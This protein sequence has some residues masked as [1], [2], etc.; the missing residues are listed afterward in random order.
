MKKLL[1]FLFLQSTLIGFATVQI[2]PGLTLSHGTRSYVINYVNE[3]VQTND[4]V[5]LGTDAEYSFSYVQLQHDYYDEVG[6][7][8]APMYPAYTMFLQVPLF[9]S[10]V[11]IHIHSLHYEQVTLNFPYIP[12]QSTIEDEEF[13]V[14]MDNSLYDDPASMDHYYPDWC[15]LE[16][17]YNRLGKSGINFTIYPVHYH[18]DGNADVLT[19]ATFEI[20]YDGPALSQLYEEIDARAVS[21]FDNYRD[22]DVFNDDINPVID[23][24]DYLIITEQQ[25][26]DSILVFKEHKESLGYNVHV[27]YVED[28]GNSPQDI[29]YCIIS[30]YT[31]CNLK[32]V[33]LVGSLTA[34]PFS[35]GTQEDFFDPPTDIY[36]TCL[37]NLDI[38]EQSE[39]HPHVF[40]GRWDCENSY[41]LSKVMR[42][43]MRSELSMF[44]NEPNRIHAFS[45]TGNVGT[46]MNKNQAK[47]I[48]TNVITP[49]PH[50]VGD[51]TDGRYANIG[52]QVS[53]YDMQTEL[54]D[55]DNPLWM[56]L[57]FG[58]GS[59]NWLADPYRFMWNDMYNCVN[60]HLPYQPFGFAFSCYVGNLYRF[61]CFAREWLCSGEG[62]I[63]MMAA[64]EKTIIECNKWFSRKMFSQLIEKQS[65]LTIGELIANAKE[66][67][68]YADK[69]LYRRNHAAKYVL[70]GDPSLYI[71]GLDVYNPYLISPERSNSQKDENQVHKVRVFSVSGLFIGEYSYNELDYLEMLD[72]AYLLQMLDKND[73]IVQTIK[74]VY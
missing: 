10:N 15:S 60:H 54:T 72:G 8:C 58:H 36:Y 38:N 22:R 14:C 5:L 37:D 40:L 65:S 7:E 73:N 25:Y 67:Y 21:F 19:E 44:Y 31:S 42:K 17:P 59:W 2:Q 29:R 11:Q 23:N 61:D 13:F 66:K 53:Y 46:L 64:T 30:H 6:E 50:I 16:P 28:I 26:E 12:V 55:T 27:A 18:S 32:Y 51:Y 62:G 33:L 43:T 71:Y 48:K 45:G 34:I 63:T 41:Y 35:N 74:K 24:E 47:W 20:T 52:N 68:Y 3:T 49:A 57:Y 9:A 4:T 39:L 70:L 69:V 56:F 1:L